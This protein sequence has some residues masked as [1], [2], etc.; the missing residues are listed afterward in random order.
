[1]LNSRDRRTRR[2][3]GALIFICRKCQNAK[4]T[5]LQEWV[6]VVEW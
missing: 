2:E 4:M 5:Y 1:M 6:F 3:A